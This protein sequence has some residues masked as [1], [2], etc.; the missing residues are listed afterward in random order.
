MPARWDHAAAVQR[1]GGEE[2]LL[3]ELI[4]IFFEDYPRLAARLDRGL[5]QAD[6]AALRE[7]AHSLKGSLGYLGAPE[8]AA[9]ARELESAARQQDLSA[10]A[11]RTERLMV[12]VEELRKAMSAS[13]GD[14]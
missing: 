3:Q 13:V 14:R 5:E 7:A 6:F 12:E 10:A 2:P 11:E 4:T 1:L 8:I 9:C